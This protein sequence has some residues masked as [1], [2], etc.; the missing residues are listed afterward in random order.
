MI[1]DVRYLFLY[2]IGVTVD[3]ERTLYSFNED[4]GTVTVTLE[5]NRQ[6]AEDFSVQVIGGINTLTIIR[7]L[8]I[9]T[10]YRSYR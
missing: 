10:T 7:M 9:T 8:V 5:L 6:I 1:D 4:D 2:Y 3:F